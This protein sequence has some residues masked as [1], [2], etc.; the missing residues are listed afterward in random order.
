[1][2]IALCSQAICMQVTFSSSS[3]TAFG[4]QQQA[5]TSEARSGH[6]VSRLRLIEVEA[7]CTCQLCPGAISMRAREISL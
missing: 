1:M 4:Q 6:Y 2:S 5:W 3:C 7:V